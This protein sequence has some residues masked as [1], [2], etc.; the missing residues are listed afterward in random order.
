MVGKKFRVQSPESRVEKQ[1]SRLKILS[2]GMVGKKG[3]GSL[4]TDDR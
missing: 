1:E 3:G 2:D 4:K